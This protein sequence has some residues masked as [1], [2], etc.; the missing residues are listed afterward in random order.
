MANQN[1]LY[2]QKVLNK[3]DVRNIA[4]GKIAKG[5]D[6]DVDYQDIKKKINKFF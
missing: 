3:D 2:I 1:F 5:F 6:R 4:E